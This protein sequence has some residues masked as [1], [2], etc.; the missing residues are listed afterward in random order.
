MTVLNAGLFYGST[1]IG[2]SGITS[3]PGSGC[4]SAKIQLISTL[5]DEFDTSKYVHTYQIEVDVS[6]SDPEFI[7]AILTFTQK[8]KM[9]DFTMQGGMVAK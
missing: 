3:L 6:L 1:C 5:D 9:V 2:T 7:V 8:V 4:S